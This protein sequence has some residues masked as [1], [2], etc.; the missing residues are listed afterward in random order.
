MANVKRN[1][2]S[3][4]QA[5][6]AQPGTHMDGGGLML[7]VHPSGGKELGSPSDRRT[8]GAGNFGLGG[9]PEVSLREAREHAAEM[10]DLAQHGLDPAVHIR[11]SA[12]KKAGY[13]DV[14]SKPPSPS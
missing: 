3:P 12:L 11:R 10:R 4:L 8:G 14:R 2:L 6:H 5:K 9:Y 1:K 7:R 13:P